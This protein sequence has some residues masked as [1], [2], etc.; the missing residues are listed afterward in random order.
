MKLWLAAILFAGL[1]LCSQAVA[2]TPDEAE[3]E[4]L[5]SGTNPASRLLLDQAGGA[6]I[7]T[8]HPLCRHE[9]TERTSLREGWQ[10]FR[11]MYAFGQRKHTLVWKIRLERGLV[12]G[13]AFMEDTN[14]VKTGKLANSARDLVAEL[15]RRHLEQSKPV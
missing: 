13:I 2:A 8:L 15:V 10:E 7:R 1:G 3:A 5:F 14:P 6:V 9:A 11:T 12:T 4:L